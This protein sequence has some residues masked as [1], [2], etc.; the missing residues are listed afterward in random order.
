M[1]KEVQS[2]RKKQTCEAHSVAGTDLRK[3]STD[4][5]MNGGN[6]PNTVGMESWFLENSFLVSPNINTA[7]NRSAE[8]T[9]V[10]VT[11]GV[12]FNLSSDTVITITIGKNYINDVYPFAFDKFRE[13][14]PIFT[15]S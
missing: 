4:F 10:F 12:S 3:T 14:D 2:L 13:N 11:L 15:L 6:D 8:E 9:I 7:N 1:I 5:D